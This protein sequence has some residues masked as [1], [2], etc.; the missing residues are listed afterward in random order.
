M[1]MF[2]NVGMLQRTM[3]FTGRGS[4]FIQEFFIEKV[5]EYD[6]EIPQSHTADQPTRS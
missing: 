3:N 6:Q 5:S 1:F 4:H 2:C